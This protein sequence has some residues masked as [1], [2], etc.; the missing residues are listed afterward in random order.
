MKR[1]SLAL[2]RPRTHASMPGR[3]DHRTFKHNLGGLDILLGTSVQAFAQSPG[4]VRVSHTE[5]GVLLCHF[6]HSSIAQSSLCEV[7]LLKMVMRLLCISRRLTARGTTLSMGLIPTSRPGPSGEGCCAHAVCVAPEQGTRCLRSGGSLCNPFIHKLHPC[8]S[9]RRL[10]PA[11]VPFS[12]NPVGFRATPALWGW[13]GASWPADS[14]DLCWPGCR[15]SEPTPPLP[16]APWA[17][18]AR[19]CRTPPTPGAWQPCRA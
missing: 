7:L 8:D 17:S 13:P 9:A 6:R 10:G 19:R 16:W 11:D 12:A 1:L 15:A 4:E 18:R 14:A 2:H 3:H 5:D